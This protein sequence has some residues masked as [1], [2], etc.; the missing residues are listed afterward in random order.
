MVIFEQ[1]L[2]PTAACDP[3]SLLH[4]RGKISENLMTGELPKGCDAAVVKRFK[5][6]S[7]DWAW[8]WLLSGH[9]MCIG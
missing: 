6:K 7:P 2:W 9:A 3:V 4:Y 1:A 8:N 5:P